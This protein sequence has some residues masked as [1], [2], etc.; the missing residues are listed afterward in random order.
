MA[1]SE[2]RALVR[3][4]DAARMAGKHRHRSRSDGERPFRLPGMG[5]P[6]KPEFPRLAGSVAKWRDPRRRRSSVLPSGA[7]ARGW[8]A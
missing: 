3:G 1:A 8:L 4:R 2:L 5:Q 6:A 7:C